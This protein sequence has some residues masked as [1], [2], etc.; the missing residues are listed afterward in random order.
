MTETPE[1]EG[2]HEWRLQKGLTFQQMLVKQ[3]GSTRPHLSCVVQNLV[4]RWPGGDALVERYCQLQPVNSTKHWINKPQIP[5]CLSWCA[6]DE[7]LRLPGLKPWRKSQVL[8]LKNSRIRWDTPCM[9]AAIGAVSAGQ[10]C[11]HDGGMV[12]VVFFFFN[13]CRRFDLLHY[14]RKVGRFF[15]E[16][17]CCIIWG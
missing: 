2:V 4:A 3:W 12:A 5:S 1:C 8:Q 17:E 6:K 14:C 13:G 15:V 7:S 16:N 11:C 9:N 10:V